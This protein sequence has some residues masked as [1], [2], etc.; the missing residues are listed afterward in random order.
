M[1]YLTLGRGNKLTVLEV[2]SHHVQ[3]LQSDF[4]IILS[5][6]HCS[7]SVGTDLKLLFLLVEER[8]SVV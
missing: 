7:G 5:D 1:D 6:M 8:V 4:Q 2:N 3:E